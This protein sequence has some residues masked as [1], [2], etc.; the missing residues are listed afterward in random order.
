MQIAANQIS[1][2][3]HKI[4]P[5]TPVPIY[6]IYGG[7]PQQTLE[8][9]LAINTHLQQHGFNARQK[10]IA[11][12]PK[13]NWNSL[14]EFN[15]N[16]SLFSDKQVLELELKPGCLGSTGSTYLINF[17][18]NW[19]ADICL[20]II[21]DKL[22]TTALKTKWFTEISRFGC[23]INCKP[24][25]AKNFPA[26]AVARF[27]AAGFSLSPA[28]TNTLSG[29]TG[30]I[31]G[32]AQ[33]IMRLQLCFKAPCKL[34]LDDIAP[35]V[36]QDASFSVFELVDNAINFDLHGTYKT[37]QC[38]KINKIDPIIVIW[39]FVREVRSLITI[40]YMTQT[41]V[42]LA[43]ACKANGV[44]STRIS[45]IRSFLTTTPV[46]YLEKLL[47]NALAVDIITKNIAQGLIWESLFTLYLKLA[48]AKLSINPEETT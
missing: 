31:L 48:G 38:L 26:Y 23:V 10:F 45:A 43:D 19:T 46:I 22:E 44:W 21:T 1:S 25:P 15:S 7:E 8:T 28:A 14:T 5:S 3:W 18:A 2:N 24:I 9:H 39:A 37:L 41:G 35:Y 29:Y 36:E 33:L 20:L 6:L 13:F 27:N 42:P 12:T 40:H 30:N 32:L 17:L 4:L 16:L 47:Q 34:E 11:D